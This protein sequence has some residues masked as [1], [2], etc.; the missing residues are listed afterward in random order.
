LD[1]RATISPSLLVTRHLQRQSGAIFPKPACIWRFDERDRNTGALHLNPDVLCATGRQRHGEKFQK[2]PRGPIPKNATRREKMARRLRTKKGRAD[3][4]RRKAIVKP[5]FGQVKVRQHA[6]QL[7]LRGLAGAQ[8]E[9]TLHMLCHNLRKL[10]NAG[11]S[12]A[13]AFA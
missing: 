7:R 12:A 1:D 10:Q 5:V 2:T 6:G 11:G 4:A 9:W 3:Y 13:L 8:G